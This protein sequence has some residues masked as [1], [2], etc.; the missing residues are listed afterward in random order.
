[1]HRIVVDEFDRHL[2]G[3]ASQA[4]YDH[5][6]VCPN[7]RAQVAELGNLS[8][9]FAELKPQEPPPAGLPAEPPP[10]FYNRVAFRIVEQQQSQ[11]W[12]LF[13]AGPAFFRRVAFAALLLL[14]ALGTVLIT[15][16]TSAG[17][18]DVAAIIAERDVNR[19]EV[20]GADRNRLLVTL[21]NYGR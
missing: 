7:C 12:G 9:F 4:F 2:A 8:P 3:N 1:M 17:D 6:V 20:Q 13:L 21:A 19:V 5:L 10:G 11:A 14:G 18:T 15:R 16:E